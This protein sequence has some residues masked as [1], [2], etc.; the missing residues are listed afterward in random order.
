MSAFSYKAGELFLWNFSPRGLYR[1]GSA[2]KPIHPKPMFLDKVIP[3]LCDSSPFLTHIFSTGFRKVLVSSSRPPGYTRTLEA[4]TCQTENP[5]AESCRL[6]IGLHRQGG[7]FI[8]KSLK[9]SGIHCAGRC[10]RSWIRF[11]F[12]RSYSVVMQNMR[13]PLWICGTGRMLRPA[14]VLWIGC[15]TGDGP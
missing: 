6:L 4:Q 5:P 14:F 11:C 1:R 10:L 12:G 8:C 7:V 13:Y 9:L 3:A 2:V 15:G